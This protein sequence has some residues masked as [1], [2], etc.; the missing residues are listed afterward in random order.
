MKLKLMLCMAVGLFWLHTTVVAHAGER[1][2]KDSKEVKDEKRETA[3]DK[4]FKEQKRETVK[5]MITIHKMD[6]KVYLSFP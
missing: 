2:K 3:Y 4:L 5:G 1:K 6:G